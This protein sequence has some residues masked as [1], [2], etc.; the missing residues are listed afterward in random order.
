MPKTKIDCN[1][2]NCT[3]FAEHDSEQV[4]II[5]FQNYLASHQQ[6]LQKTT[7]QKLPPIERPTI[8]QDIT[9]EEWDSFN[10]EWKRFKRCTDIPI[11]QEAD[12]L[13][14]YCEKGLGDLKPKHNRSRGR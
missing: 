13:F 11:S 6:P 4:D 3:Y 2:P 5:Q 12:Q 14:D 1:F 8:K 9:E 7:K 10:Q